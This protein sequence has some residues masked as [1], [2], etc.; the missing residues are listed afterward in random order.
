[1]TAKTTAVRMPTPGKHLGKFDCKYY[2]MFEESDRTEYI[3]LRNDDNDPASG[4]SI[5]LIKEFIRKIKDTTYTGDQQTEVHEEEFP[6]VYV[7]WW[8]SK[9]RR[10]KGD[11]NDEKRKASKGWRD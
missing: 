9:P 4:V 8:V 11:S 2:N 7:E 6:H 1:M 10:E 5:S 3:A